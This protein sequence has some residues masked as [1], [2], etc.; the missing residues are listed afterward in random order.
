M[1]EIVY[2]Q[3]ERNE[4]SKTIYPYCWPI[5]DLLSGI[6][7]TVGHIPRKVSRYPFILIVENG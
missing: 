2:V 3:I 1:D 7:R 4:A 5:R 6:L